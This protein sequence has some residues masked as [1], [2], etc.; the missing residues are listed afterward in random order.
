M[1]L[2]QLAC[3]CCSCLVWMSHVQA[4]IIVKQST[5]RGRRMQ[6]RQRPP[7]PFHLRIFGPKRRKRDK[8]LLGPISSACPVSHLILSISISASLPQALQGPTA[9]LASLQRTSSKSTPVS[10]EERRPVHSH[11]RTRSHS[12]THLVYARR[13]EPQ[14]TWRL[15]SSSST[16]SRPSTMARRTSTFLVRPHIQNIH[17]THA[18]RNGDTDNMQ[19]FASSTRFAW[20]RVSTLLS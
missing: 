19:I 5:E 18:R 15:H 4:I 12:H 9:N 16:P 13:R 1:I 6:A 11:Q 20:R 17:H 7:L 14:S 8:T 3:M 2:I 10:K